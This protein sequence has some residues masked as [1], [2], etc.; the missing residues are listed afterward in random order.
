MITIMQERIEQLFAG[1]LTRRLEPAQPLFH[2]ADVVAFMYFVLQGQIT[3]SRQTENGATVILQQAQSGQV[4][5]EASA[6]SSTYH[7]NAQATRA[8][9]V[10]AVPVNLFHNRLKQDANL[11]QV[12]ASYLAS[13]VQSARMLAEIRTLRKVGD[14]LDAWLEQGRTM[15][16]KG[17]WQELASQLGVTREALYRELAGRRSIPT[18]LDSHIR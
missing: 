17:K 7:C 6:F 5:A 14:R 13:Q 11:S 2:V 1:G 4:L 18:T 3:L 9:H 16:P 8:T 10:R 12:W 15:P